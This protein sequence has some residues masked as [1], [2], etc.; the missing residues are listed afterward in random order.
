MH[1]QYV[2]LTC[3]HV[4]VFFLVKK[5]E[6]GINRSRMSLNTYQN[7]GYVNLKTKHCSNESEYT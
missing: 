3:L 2:I 1:F 5:L 7:K 4:R 6:T